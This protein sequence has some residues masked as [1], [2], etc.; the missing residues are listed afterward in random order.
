MDKTAL[1]ILLMMIFIVLFFMFCVMMAGK[2]MRHNAVQKAKENIAINN[3]IVDLSEAGYIRA[4][5]TKGNREVSKSSGQ[6]SLTLFQKK[7]LDIGFSGDTNLLSTEA[8]HTN[9]YK[10]REELVVALK[11]SAD[12][13]YETKPSNRVYSSSDEGSAVVLPLLFLGTAEGSHFSYNPAYHDSPGYAGSS[14]M[15]GGGS[16]SGGGDGGG[17]GGGD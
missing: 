9:L 17:G 12:V 13:D 8:F 11:T 16:D 10:A 7:V 1:F 3:A 14:E 4:S 6:G 5:G 15:S 2:A